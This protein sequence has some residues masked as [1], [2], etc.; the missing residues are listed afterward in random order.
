MTGQ[1]DVMIARAKAAQAR[2]E[3]SGS[4]DQILSRL[5][6]S[7]I[8]SHAFGGTTKG[9]TDWVALGLRFYRYRGTAMTILGLIGGLRARRKRKAAERRDQVAAYPP[10][11]SRGYKGKFRKGVSEMTSSLKDTAGMAREKLGA[12]ADRAADARDRAGEKL[13]AAYSY[14]RDRGQELGGRLIDSV[15]ENP[16]TAVIGGIALGVLAGAL[17]PRLGGRSKAAR[18]AT[19]FDRY[20]A[21]AVGT[22]R[23]TLQVVGG[24]LDELGVNRENARETLSKAKDVVSDV[25][26]IASGA[27]RDAIQR[28]KREL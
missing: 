17:L 4:M 28:V 22:A 13:N 8:A 20:R 6:P 1:N 23:D 9:K 5:T 11:A 21:R 10:R 2:E 24:R 27:T 15:R 12:A 7:G 26:A 25:T 16:V 3:L 19:A 14:S 18:A